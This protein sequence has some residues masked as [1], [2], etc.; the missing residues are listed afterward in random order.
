MDCYTICLLATAVQFSPLTSTTNCTYCVEARSTY[1][2]CFNDVIECAYRDPS[3]LIICLNVYEKNG[4]D[5]ALV[6]H[7]IRCI[8]Y[9]DFYVRDDSIKQVSSGGSCAFEHIQKCDCDVCRPP[10]TTTS[11]TTSSTE[12]VPSVHKKKHHS[13]HKGNHHKHHQQQLVYPNNTLAQRYKD[14]GYYLTSTSSVTSLTLIS[15]SFIQLYLLF[16]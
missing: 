6:Q 15:F 10:P 11:S 5:H 3:S 2:H 4:G 7:T 14:S 16:Q 13:H 12:V 9:Q 1:E 8:S